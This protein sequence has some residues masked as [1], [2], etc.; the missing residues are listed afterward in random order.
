MFGC[1]SI[2]GETRWW[3]KGKWSINHI[4]LTFVIR[5]Q[6]KLQVAEFTANSHQLSSWL[7][8]FLL[9]GVVAVPSASDHTSDEEWKTLQSR[10]LKSG[11]LV[12]CRQV[13]PSPANPGHWAVKLHFIHTTTN[14]PHLKNLFVQTGLLRQHFEF[15]W[16]WVLVNLEV[17]LHNSELVMF[18][19]G[20][21]PL[22][23]GLTHP[24]SLHARWVAL[25]KYLGN[26]E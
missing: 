22:G 23:L 1:W 10:S 12:R 19:G 8:P 25:Q 5:W 7:M 17:R 14:S 2:A 21:R 4:T 24:V 26:N 16:I 11:P 9:P 6:L 3:D 13:L 20:P 18:E 15:S